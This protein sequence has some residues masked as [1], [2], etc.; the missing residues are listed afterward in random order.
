MRGLDAKL[1]AK[2]AYYLVVHKESAEIRDRGFSA[3][4]YRDS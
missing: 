1:Y 2:L 4:A 3:F